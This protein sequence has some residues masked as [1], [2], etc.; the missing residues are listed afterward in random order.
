MRNIIIVDMFNDFSYLVNSLN[1]VAAYLLQD[2]RSFFTIKKEK[3]I[4]DE[5]SDVIPE[6]PDVE[7]NKKVCFHF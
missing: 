6:S 2:I 1:T 4:K 3:K 7:V 5:D